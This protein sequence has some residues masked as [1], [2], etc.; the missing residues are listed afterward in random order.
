MTIRYVPDKKREGEFLLRGPVQELEPGTI[1]TVATKAGALRPET[2]GSVL[3]TGY[4]DDN[5]HVALATIASDDEV[6][7]DE[8][9]TNGV[10]PRVALRALYKQLRAALDAVEAIGK[11]L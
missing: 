10:E 1:V 8:G 6:D 11:S 2:V 7:D 3:W 9:D 5:N 4:D